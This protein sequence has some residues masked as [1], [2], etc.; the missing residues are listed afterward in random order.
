MGWN[1]VVPSVAFVKLVQRGFPL[2]CWVMSVYRLGHSHL[3]TD[4]SSWDWTF[5]WGD[6]IGQK[7]SPRHIIFIV[8]AMWMFPKIVV[9][10][11]HPLKNRVFPLFS[12]SILGCFALFLETAMWTVM[13]ILM[14]D[15][16]KPFLLVT[17]ATGNARH[18]RPWK[19]WRCRIWSPKDVEIGEKGD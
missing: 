11:T 15:G 1:L 5:P 6:F 13:A 7:T 14:V 19:S 4:V 10:P 2:L 17:F 8:I 18:Q 12:P 16:A 9:P 3:S